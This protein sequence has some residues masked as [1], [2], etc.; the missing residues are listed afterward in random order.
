MTIA[1]SP[2][3]ISKNVDS[4][5]KI[6]KAFKEFLL[7]NN[8]A[9]KNIAMWIKTPYSIK[10]FIINE[11]PKSPNKHVVPCTMYDIL[12]ICILQGFTNIQL[13]YI[14]KVYLISKTAK[15]QF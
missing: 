2:L 11:K 13:T 12:R 10:I 6:L 5:H 7:L 14:K 1:I 3:P 15:V 9:M 8:N 4:V